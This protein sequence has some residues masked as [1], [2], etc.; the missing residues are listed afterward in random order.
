MCAIY[1]DC[2][3]SIL[4]DIRMIVSDSDR[5]IVA[6]AQLVKPWNQCK[7]FLKTVGRHSTEVEIPDVLK[8]SLHHSTS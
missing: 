1:V 5:V 8:N 3:V 6:A 4:E 7:V 2:A